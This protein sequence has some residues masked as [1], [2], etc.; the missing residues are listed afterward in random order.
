MAVN[1]KVK[2]LGNVRPF[3]LVDR[4][5]IYL[6]A[7]CLHLHDNLELNTACSFKMLVPSYQTIRRYVPENCDFNSKILK[8]GTIRY[9]ALNCLVVTISE[10]FP[11]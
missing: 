5:Q 11:H 7:C 2:A 9:K 1:I 10:V 8:K 3:S 6:E 4:D